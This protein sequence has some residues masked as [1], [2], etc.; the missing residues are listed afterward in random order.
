VHEK[1]ETAVIGNYTEQNMRNTSLRKFSDAELH[2]ILKAI[3]LLSALVI[4]KPAI[5]ISRFI[6]KSTIERKTDKTS[7]L[8][9]T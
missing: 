8:H 5:M 1:K 7:D 2:F 9:I 4:R 3:G 6:H